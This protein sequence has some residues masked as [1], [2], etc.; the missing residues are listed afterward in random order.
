[1]L[2]MKTKR[3]TGGI[4]SHTLGYSWQSPFSIFLNSSLALLAEKQLFAMAFLALK[5]TGGVAT[6]QQPT[7]L[8]VS[9]ET[10]CKTRGLEG[11]V[12]LRGGGTVSTTDDNTFKSSDRKYQ[13]VIAKHLSL[14]VDCTKLNLL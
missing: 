2:E 3:V 10:K 14:N 7:E 1:M 9:S 8:D 12:V 5:C 4:F 11:I 13:S 6:G